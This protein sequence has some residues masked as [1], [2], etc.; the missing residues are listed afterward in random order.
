MSS[1]QAFIALGSNM[2]DRC[3]MIES[4]L[5]QL[6]QATDVEVV[7]VSSLFETEPIGMEA[8]DAFL[9]AAAE[10]RTTLSARQLLELCLSIEAQHGRVRNP[11]VRWG[12]RLIDIDLLLFADLVI[13]EPG[14]R[15]PHPRMAERAF[16]LVPLAQIAGNQRHPVI[17]STIGQM[18]LAS[19]S[20]GIKEY[21]PVRQCLH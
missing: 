6:N 11:N 17:G 12:P 21:Q 1:V 18:R 16:V 5:K 13:D 14:L 10:L 8:Q 19:A 15:V 3:A 20:A 9:N 4:A 2:G 7:R